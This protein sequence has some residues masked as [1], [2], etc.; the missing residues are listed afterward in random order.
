MKTESQFRIWTRCI[1]REVSIKTEY[2]ETYPTYISFGGSGT[3]NPLREI[4]PCETGL[5]GM[6]WAQHFQFYDL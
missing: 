2:E 3:L 5:F 6:S 1:E 4:P